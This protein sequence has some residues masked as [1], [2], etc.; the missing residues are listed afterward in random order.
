M[1]DIIVQHT[2]EISF[3]SKII[4]VNHLGEYNICI[5]TNASLG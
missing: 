1:E 3:V 2:V 4:E 5:Q